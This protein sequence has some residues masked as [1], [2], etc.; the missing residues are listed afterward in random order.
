MS[1]TIFVKIQQKRSRVG[2]VLLLGALLAAL[3]LSVAAA[4]PDPVLEWNAIMN[5]T[6]IAGGTSPLVTSRVVALVSASV[7]D[8]VNGIKPRYQPLHVRPA[9]LRRGTP[10]NAQ[11]R[12]KQRMR[13]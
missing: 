10:R 9:A 3:P 8:A 2:L 13:C 6:V 12:F 7:F 11:P 5:D 4:T 1:Q